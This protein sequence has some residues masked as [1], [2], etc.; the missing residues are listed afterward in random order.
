MMKTGIINHLTFKFSK[1]SKEQI[2]LGLLI[3]YKIVTY[4]NRKWND[5]NQAVYIKNFED[6]LSDIKEPLTNSILDYNQAR[7][8]ERENQIREMER[9]RTQE[10]LVRTAL[11]ATAVRR[12]RINN[13][14][15]RAIAAIDKKIARRATRNLRANLELEKT[16]NDRYL[17]LW[18]RFVL[19]PLQKSAKKFLASFKPPKE[20]KEPKILESQPPKEEESDKPT[21]FDLEQ[22]ER[23]LLWSQ[24]NPCF[25]SIMFRSIITN[26][27]GNLDLVRA[28]YRERGLEV[29]P[30]AGPFEVSFSAIQRQTMIRGPKLLAMNNYTFEKGLQR[31]SKTTGLLY[32]A[33]GIVFQIKAWPVG[34]LDSATGWSYQMF[35]AT[36]RKPNRIYS[37]HIDESK[38][39]LALGLFDPKLWVGEPLILPLQFGIPVYN[40]AWTPI[41]SE[42]KPIHR[43]GSIITTDKSVVAA[44]SDLSIFAEEFHPRLYTCFDCDFETP[45]DLDLEELEGKYLCELCY[46]H[47]ALSSAEQDIDGNMLE[48]DE[49]QFL[50]QAIGE[51]S[52]KIEQIDPIVMEAF[53][54]DPARQ[55]P[56]W[57]MNAVLQGQN[58][59]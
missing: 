29:S 15:L 40:K 58:G 30:F 50:D 13:H 4:L 46:N 7:Q 59:W 45:N 20:T 14:K 18:A 41:I 19:K 1:I 44:A 25:R 36:P 5:Y 23:N 33:P 6:L 52:N 47:R 3:T 21:R 16:I 43:I 34:K 22:S 24:K 55:G 9:L 32:K 8:I 39:I 53:D 10:R 49:Q 35:K 28:G 31:W 57:S 54:L 11:L 48:P 27:D 38:K 56:I 37:V 42:Q 17:E 2:A 51:M 26:L 12:F